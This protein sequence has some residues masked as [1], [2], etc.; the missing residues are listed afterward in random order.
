MP[1]ITGEFEIKREMQPSRELGDGI[2][3]MHVRFEKTFHGPLQAQ[4]VVQMLGYMA[5]T[6]GSGGYVAIERIKGTLEGREGSFVV[7]HSGTM[8]R[9]APTLR[10]DVIPDSATEQ[11]SGLRGEMRIDIVDGRHFYTFDYAFE[12]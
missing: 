7:Q 9:G 6:E 12:N 5:A 1:Q 11:L 8:A 4:S 10:I 2:A 3:A